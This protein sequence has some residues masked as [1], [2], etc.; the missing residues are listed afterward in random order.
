MKTVIYSDDQ[1]Y[2][3]YLETVER[4]HLNY[5][6]L[7]FTDEIDD[8]KTFEDVEDAK[9][10]LDDYIFVERP[11]T[12]GVLFVLTLGLNPLWKLYDDAMRAVI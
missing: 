1:G 7:A 3:A 9:E 4:N 11:D 6:I 10:Y 8:A 12:V 5:M 2:R